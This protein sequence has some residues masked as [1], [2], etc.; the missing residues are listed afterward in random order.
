MD[1]LKLKFRYYLTTVV[2]WMLM[3]FWIVPINRNKV[4][5]ISHSGKK[6][7]DSPRKLSNAIGEM[8]PKKKQIW[9]LNDVPKDYPGGIKHVRMHS[10]KF[11]YHICTAGTIITNN[12]IDSY[13]P[14]RK[15][16]ILL[17]TFHGGGAGKKFGL[18]E[19]NSSPY[20][21]YFLK[22]QEKKTTAVISNSKFYTQNV[23]I[24]SM[25]FRD[26][27]I[28]ECGQPRNDVLFGYTEHIK[29]SV[30]KKLGITNEKMVLYAPSFRGSH[31]D[32]QYLPENQFLDVERV[33]RTLSS[34]YKNDFVLLFR[35]H[36]YM[37]KVMLGKSI[38]VSDYPEIIDLYCAVD[39]LITDYS[40]CMNEFALTRKPV[41]LYVPDYKKYMSNDKGLYWKLEEMP[42]PYSESNEELEKTILRFSNEKYQQNLEDYWNHIGNYEDGH[43]TECVMK[44]LEKKWLEKKW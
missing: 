15:K 27:T 9:V 29:Q 19:S 43:G 32:A 23:I 20:Y 33:T 1:E 16:Q 12:T 18:S 11:F 13:I 21:R 14:I 44:W 10:F 22:I 34:V 7:A 40:S 26:V 25:G 41:F 4:L 38:D 42:F 17:N 31:K 5:F 39:V 8:F 36:P 35:R 2:S 30:K 37:K 24:D 6:Y 28:I 3:V